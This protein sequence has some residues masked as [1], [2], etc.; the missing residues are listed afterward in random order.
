[1]SALFS[2]GEEFMNALSEFTKGK[3]VNSEDLGRIVSL[4]I[5]NNNMGLFGDLAFEGKYLTGL[6][7]IIRN[8]DNSFEEEYFSKIKEEYASHA[9]RVKELISLII[10]PG[11]NFIKDILKRKYFELNRESLENLNSLCEDLGRVKS[12]LNSLK[13][14]GKGF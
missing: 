1:M 6:I 9:D 2:S 10:E 3:I 4:A 14:G 8:R 7:R 13:E 11:S 12:F 5:E